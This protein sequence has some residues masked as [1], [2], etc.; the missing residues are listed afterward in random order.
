MA[1]FSIIHYRKCKNQHTHPPNQVSKATP[2]KQGMREN[3]D[4]VQDSGS[5]C[6]EARADFKEGIDD[7]WNLSR[8]DKWKSTKEG[9]EN[10]T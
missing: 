9:P 8:K 1:I 5:C 6:G 10:P 3:T 7:I 2:E 4:I